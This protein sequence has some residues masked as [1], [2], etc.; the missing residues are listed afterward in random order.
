MIDFVLEKHQSPDLKLSCKFIAT[1]FVQSRMSHIHESSEFEARFERLYCFRGCCVTGLMLLSKYANFCLFA[2]LL[3]SFCVEKCI[4][5]PFKNKVCSQY[6]AYM[7]NGPF[8]YT[9]LG[10]K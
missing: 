8:S 6:Q 10:K 3:K 7:V 5:K 9:P 1:L 4:S 2:F